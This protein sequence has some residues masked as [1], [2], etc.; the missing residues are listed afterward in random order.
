L[1]FSDVGGISF[2]PLHCAAYAARSWG[3]TSLCEGGEAPVLGLVLSRQRCVMNY[4]HIQATTT[5][6]TCITT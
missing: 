1:I 4:P 2:R 5:G 6:T 3:E